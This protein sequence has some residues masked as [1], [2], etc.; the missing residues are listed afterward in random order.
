MNYGTTGNEHK[1]NNII[2][3]CK[4]CTHDNNTVY[5]NQLYV[6]AEDGLYHFSCYNEKVEKENEEK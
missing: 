4:H 5:D 6:E 3:V 2:G 1:E